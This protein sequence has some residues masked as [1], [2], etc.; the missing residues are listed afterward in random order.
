MAMAVG[1]IKE[2]SRQG[3]IDL[4]NVMRTRSG[5]LCGAPGANPSLESLYFE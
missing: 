5:A 2:I 1:G 4:G 3:V